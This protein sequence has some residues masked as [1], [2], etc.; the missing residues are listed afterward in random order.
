[1]KLDRHFENDETIIE[2]ISNTIFIISD[3]GSFLYVR[4]IK[5]NT[6]FTYF[7]LRRNAY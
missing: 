5:E 1:M 3:V 6:M 4:Q 7:C 2:K